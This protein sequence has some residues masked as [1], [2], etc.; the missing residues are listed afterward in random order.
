MAGPEFGEDE[1]KVMTGEGGCYELKTSAARFHK[2]ISQEL[3][4][5]G[6]ELAKLTLTCV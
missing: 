4:A 6:F 1:E 3:R 2:R 5:M